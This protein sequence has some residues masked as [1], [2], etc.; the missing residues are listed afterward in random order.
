MSVPTSVMLDS[1][2][3][4]FDNDSLRKKAI[5]ENKIHDMPKIK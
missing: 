5:A 3:S 2:I 4:D 1:N